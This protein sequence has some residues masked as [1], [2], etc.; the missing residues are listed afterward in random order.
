MGNGLILFATIFLLN[1]CCNLPLVRCGPVI[2][3]LDVTP[4]KQPLDSNKQLYLSVKGAQY[5]SR[6]NN[7]AELLD[8]ECKVLVKDTNTTLLVYDVSNYLIDAN[9]VRQQKVPTFEKEIGRKSRI[10]G[11]FGVVFNYCCDSFPVQVLMDSICIVNK[12]D[13]AYYSAQVTLFEKGE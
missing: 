7:N 4:N 3:E 1:G 13:T 12:L 6:D 11:K 10:S 8:L 9:N 5:Y 2:I